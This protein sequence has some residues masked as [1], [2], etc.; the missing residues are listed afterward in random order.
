MIFLLLIVTKVAANI[1]ADFFAVQI[2]DKNQL[3]TVFTRV[4]NCSVYRSEISGSLFFQ[5]DGK[6][7]IGQLKSFGE[8]NCKNI[9]SFVDTDLMYQPYRNL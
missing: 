9:S 8:I 5:H 2:S 7:K 1:D 6:W 3:H 4:G